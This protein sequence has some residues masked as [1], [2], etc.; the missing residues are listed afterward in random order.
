MARF[1]GSIVFWGECV[2]EGGVA[3]LF[4]LCGPSLSPV[5]CLWVAYLT[6]YSMVD[7]R[8]FRA[9]LDCNIGVRGCCHPD[10]LCLSC[11][12]HLVVVSEGGASDGQRALY[13]DGEVLSW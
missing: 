3:Q 11:L 9:W 10:G 8:P 5:D 1:A 2:V 7:G 4:Y 12:G 6:L 13:G